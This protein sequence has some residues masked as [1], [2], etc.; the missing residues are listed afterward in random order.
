[1]AGI[2]SDVAGTKTER[3]DLQDQ[4]KVLQARLDKL[5][6][7]VR[8]QT[9]WRRRG[10]WVC[11]VVWWCGCGRNAEVGGGAV[12]AGAA[13]C[14]RARAKSHGGSSGRRGSQFHFATSATRPAAPCC[15]APPRAAASEQ[16]DDVDDLEAKLMAV[17]SN[18][19]GTQVR[20][21]TR[22]PPCPACSPAMWGPI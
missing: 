19:T 16:A 17:L 8:Q 4:I 12:V 2:L 9:C 18:I 6:P 7:K 3:E 15:H 10:S 14:D 5:E 22:S 11:G 20:K 21:R 1:M 13:P